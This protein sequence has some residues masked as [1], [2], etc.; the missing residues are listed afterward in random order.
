MTPTAQV[1]LRCFTLLCLLC[2]FTTAQAQKLVQLTNVSTNKT[3]T[4][5]PGTRV[6]CRARLINNAAPIVGTLTAISDS[7]V[8][9]N[10]REI[11]L[12]AV[13]AFGRKRLGSGA[14]SML[15]SATGGFILG[16]TATAAVNGNISSR[17]V[18]DA[19]VASLVGTSLIL[20]GVSIEYANSAKN[21]EAKWRLSVKDNDQYHVLTQ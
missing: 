17:A 13:F 3:I 15:L 1:V 2:T 8:T 19:I 18:D 6:I 7:T 9:I 14:G 16:Y 12:N 5:K 21:L 20:L 4:I 10:K 11:P